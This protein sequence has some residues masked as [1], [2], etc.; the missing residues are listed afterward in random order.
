MKNCHIKACNVRLH[1]AFTTW[2]NKWTEIIKSDMKAVLSVKVT[3]LLIKH[4]ALLGLTIFM[5]TV[6]TL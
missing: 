5:Q 3:K 1:T 6:A 2:I 4:N